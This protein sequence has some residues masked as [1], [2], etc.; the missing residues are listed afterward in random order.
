MKI[1]IKFAKRGRMK[2]IG[3]LDIMRYFQKAIRRAEVD[4][5]YTEGFSPHQVM[6]FAAP[7]GVGLTSE[8][9]YFDIEVHS[10]LD[11]KTMIDQLNQAMVREMEILDYVKL[12]D[13]AKNAMSIVAGADYLLTFDLMDCKLMDFEEEFKKF[14]AQS[15]ILIEKKTKKSTAVVDIRPMIFDAKVREDGLFLKLM[16]G[17][18][19]N[20]KPELVMEAFN[21]NLKFK[22]CRLETYALDAN[23]QLVPLGSL[24]EKIV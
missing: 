14:L 4:I 13:D 20:L 8:G 17:S 1:R 10:S 11:S 6:S 24:G 7:L 22:I 23:N 21:P 9:E 15:E 5:V 12:P 18:S 2:F 3:H 19:G 16:T